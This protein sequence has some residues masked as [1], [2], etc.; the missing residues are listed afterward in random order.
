MP[1]VVIIEAVAPVASWRPP[2]ALTYHRTLPLPPYTTLVGMLGAAMGLGLPESYRLMEAR[3][4][5]LGIGGWCE[6]RARDLWK[7]RKF[8]DK[9]VETDVLL[10]EMGIDARLAIVIEAPDAATAQLVA[11]AFAAPAFPLTA[12]PSDA[13]L[14]VVA[15]QVIPAA[16]PAEARSV[17]YAQVF[18]EIR[19][20]YELHGTL[21]DLPIHRTIRAPSIERLPTGFTFEPDGRRRLAGRAVVSFVADPINLDPEDEPVVG[22]RVS[23][24]SPSLR[25]SS[26]FVPWKE[27]VSWIIPVHRFDSAPT[28]AATS[29]TTP[30]PSGRTG[31]G[32]RG[33]KATGST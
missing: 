3:A 18:R 20:R 14:K 29:S 6:G 12:G 32:S 1:D 2:E 31:T 9:E 15:L 19:P 8:K 10:R 28:S 33:S 22:Y 25:E 4:L 11:D 24:H 17:A 26:V 27:K 5:R 30:S 13:L 23:P 7:F 16:E 21:A